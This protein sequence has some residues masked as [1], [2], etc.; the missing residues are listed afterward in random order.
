MSK[1]KQKVRKRAPLL[2][3]AAFFLFLVGPPIIAGY[4]PLRRQFSDPDFFLLVWPIFFLI[5][6]PIF[7]WMLFETTKRDILLAA[8]FPVLSVLLLLSSGNLNKAILSGLFAALGI[9]WD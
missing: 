9:E 3:H 2:L 4:V 8:F 6:M 5:W 1:V 7:L